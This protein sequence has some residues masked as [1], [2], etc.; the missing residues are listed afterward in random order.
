MSVSLISH[1]PYPKK[2]PS[3]ICFFR[4]Q[5]ILYN[6]NIPSSLMFPLVSVNLKTR[7]PVFGSPDLPGCPP[8]L[9]LRGPGHCTVHRG[10][11]EE[12]HIAGA[13][14][15]GKH[16]WHLLVDGLI[17]V[18]YKCILNVHIHICIMWNMLRPIMGGILKIAFWCS[19]YSI[20]VFIYVYKWMLIIKLV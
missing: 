19:M 1:E 7:S 18:F 5:K 6:Y 13:S 11:R 20:C 9:M 16:R 10:L 15:S 2:Q 14:G 12:Q 4:G 3:L 17:G 8:P